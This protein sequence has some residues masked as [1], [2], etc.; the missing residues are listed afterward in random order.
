M[1]F[2]RVASSVSRTTKELCLEDD[3]SVPI[4]YTMT[5]E[6]FMAVLNKFKRRILYSNVSNDFQVHYSTASL[7][8][9]NPYNRD[10]TRA[11]RSKK[12]PDL[13]AWSLAMVEERRQHQDMSE[14]D[15]FAKSDPRARLL[16]AMFARLNSLEWERFDAVFPTVFAH[17][18]IINKRSLFAGRDVIRHLCELFFS[19]PLPTTATPSRS[20]VD[21]YRHHLRETTPPDPQALSLG[22]LKATVKEQDDEEEFVDASTTAPS[23]KVKYLSQI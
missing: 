14:L 16:R 23:P 18:Q 17:E 13:T 12:Y 15:A 6:S 5:D 21:T 1:V 7:S 20:V 22:V 2:H 11:K 9:Y 8:L 19:R 3:V 4:L 10:P